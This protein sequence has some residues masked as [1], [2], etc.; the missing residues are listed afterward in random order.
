M[1]N[2]VKNIFKI[3]ILVEC[4]VLAVLMGMKHFSPN[5]VDA[6][7]WLAHNSSAPESF[8][9]TVQNIELQ[10]EDGTNVSVWSGSEDV[11]IAKV[12][13]LADVTAFKGD[14]PPGKYKK[15]FLTISSKYKVKGSVV[16]NGTTYYTKIAHTGYTI[17]PAELEEV[18]ILGQNMP[19]QR[20]ERVFDPVAQLGGSISE[21]HIL[22]DISNF[23]TYYDGNEQTSNEFNFGS[24]KPTAGMYLWSYL[25]Y[26]LTIG[27]PAI[28]EIY[29]YTSSTT[30]GTGLLTIIYDSDNN[31]IDAMAR[32][33]YTNN[34]GTQFKLFPS[35]AG[36]ITGSNLQKNSDGTLR[37]QMNPAPT[38]T[39]DTMGFGTIVM[40]NFQRISHTGSY[41][42]TRQGNGTY[43]ATRIQ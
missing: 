37:L 40:S 17:A 28:K 20:I 13:S 27:K 5:I 39:S 12:T 34:S 10:K 36:V 43:T 18:G 4:V 42:S 16:L 24:Y 21:A 8:I 26:A 6:I 15:F 41:T 38:D 2:K 1:I 14:I 25:P 31:P 30:I 11:D 33:L 29:E 3:T 19:Q 7:Q 32:P 22:V 35:E 23:L 9:V